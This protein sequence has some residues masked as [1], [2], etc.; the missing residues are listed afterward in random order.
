M[1][2]KYVYVVLR[3][4]SEDDDI[5][6]EIAYVASSARKAKEFL[7]HPYCRVDQLNGKINFT[8]E[9]IEI[10]KIQEIWDWRVRKYEELAPPYLVRLTFGR[11]RDFVEARLTN[12]QG[13]HKKPEDID[14]IDV[15]LPFK[16]RDTN[17]DLVDYARTFAREEYA[18]LMDKLQKLVREYEASNGK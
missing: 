18:R 17:K 8:V 10:N 14:Q 12:E 7:T 4:D 11:G 3:S 16:V 2:G 1:A 9:K 6:P 15:C 5:Y 13:K